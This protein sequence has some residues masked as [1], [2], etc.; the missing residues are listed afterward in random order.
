MGVPSPGSELS[1]TSKL[2][3]Q[4]SEPEPV[5]RSRRRGYLHCIIWGFMGGSGVPEPQI[6]NLCPLFHGDF[7]SP[8]LLKA[9]LWKKSPVSISLGGNEISFAQHFH[10]QADM[11]RSQIE[12]L[13]KLGE[14]R[15]EENSWEDSWGGAGTSKGPTVW[16]RGVSLSVTNWFT[17]WSSFLPY[18]PASQRG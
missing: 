10:W 1:A 5:A 3:L 15:G 17:L 6:E 13:W 16:P 18:H 12:T 9:Y 2:I 7:F 14:A 8:W 11:N 4:N